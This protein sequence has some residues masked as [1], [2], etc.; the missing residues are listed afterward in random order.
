MPRPMSFFFDQA[1]GLQHLKML[2]HGGT[3]DG[4]AAAELADG[5]RA[6]PKQVEDRLAG[7]VGEGRQQLASVSHTLR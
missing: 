5:R 7:R 6:S 3:T 2:G 4:Q 1:Y